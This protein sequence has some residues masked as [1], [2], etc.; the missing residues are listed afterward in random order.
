MAAQNPNTF[1]ALSD[2]E[3]LVLGNN[4][5]LWLEHAPFGHVPPTRQQVD[6]NVG[7]FQ[8]LSYTEILVLGSDGNLWLERAP[9]GHVP[10]ARQQVDANV[11]FFQALSDTEI[12]VLGSDGKLWLEARTEAL[13]HRKPERPGA[14]VFGW[15]LTSSP[16]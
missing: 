2:T 14:G 11:T 13:M 15:E 7:S 10:P 12:L 5:N 4:G 16:R 6:A 9:F 8:A 1:Q 3:I